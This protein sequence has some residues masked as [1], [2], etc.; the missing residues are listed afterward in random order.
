M[1]QSEIAGQNYNLG[2]DPYLYLENS[3]PIACDYDLAVYADGSVARVNQYHLIEHVTADFESLDCLLMLR[4]V[5]NDPMNRD[6]SK[7]ETIDRIL[8]DTTEWF[9]DSDLV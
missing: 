6:E 8:C 1:N 2:L 9:D 3:G 4:S 5:M 7:L